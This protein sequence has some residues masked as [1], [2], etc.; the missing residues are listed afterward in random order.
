MLPPIFPVL[1]ASMPVAA[2]IGP[3]PIRAFRHGHV[4]QDTVAPYVVWS[5]INILPSNNLSDLPSDDRITIEIDCYSYDDTEIVQL[6][7]AV[8]NA[9]EPHAHLTGVPVDLKE[10]ETQLYRMS[11][12]FDWFLSR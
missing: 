1:K 10:T 2:I 5:S 8:R 11:L 3:N 6:A 9:I 7:T 12:Q 4:P